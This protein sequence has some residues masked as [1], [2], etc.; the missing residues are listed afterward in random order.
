MA[1]KD[2]KPAEEATVVNLSPAAMVDS[3]AEWP[4]Q[5][6]VEH[7]RKKE[8]EADAVLE[9]SRRVSY[10]TSIRM[11]SSVIGDAAQRYGVSQSKMQRWLSYHAAALVKYDVILTTLGERYA[12]LTRIGLVEADSDVLDVLNA[13][14][15]YTPRSIDER[16]GVFDLYSA[17][18]R[19]DFQEAAIACGVHAYRIA[20][21]YMMR[22]IMTGDHDVMSD[23]M[24]EFTLESERW[25]K[26]MRMRLG[27]I[28]GM[29]EKNPFGE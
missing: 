15:P 25:G 1:D 2:G 3:V 8:Q 5:R 6:V 19:T 28:T 27:A 16:H 9:E 18:V 20:Q 29:L 12:Q 13:I 26:W 22:S 23:L 24:K 7:L 11:L 17:W 10:R 4:L 14:V 21:V